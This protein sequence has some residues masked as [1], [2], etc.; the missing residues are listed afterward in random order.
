MKKLTMV[1]VYVNGFKKT[2]FVELTAC[3]DGKYRFDVMKLMPN[4]PAGITFS[5]G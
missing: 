2:V 1:S 3:P 5:V 4:L